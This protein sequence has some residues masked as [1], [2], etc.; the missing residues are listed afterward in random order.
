MHT[1]YLPPATLR[2]RLHKFYRILNRQLTEQHGL[3]RLLQAAGEIGKLGTV[4]QRN[5]DIKLTL[6]KFIVG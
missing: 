4:G 6:E 5:G 1:C 3:L 2:R